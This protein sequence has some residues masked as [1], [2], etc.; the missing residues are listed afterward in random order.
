MAQLQ[1]P[2]LE[3]LSVASIMR[4]VKNLHEVSGPTLAPGGISICAG[5]RH[6]FGSLGSGSGR[7][8]LSACEQA[9]HRRRTWG[10]ASRCGMD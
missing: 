8:R 5:H 2:A 3:V 6:L 9:R 4:L 10:R 1:A 7:P